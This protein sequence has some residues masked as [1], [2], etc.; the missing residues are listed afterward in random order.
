MLFVKEKG[1]DADTCLNILKILTSKDKEYCE[2]DEV[3]KNMKMVE[4]SD[5]SYTMEIQIDI[6]ENELD[7]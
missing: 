2:E 1:I 7:V 6:R 3:I 5:G 4:L